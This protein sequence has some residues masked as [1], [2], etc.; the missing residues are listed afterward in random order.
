MALPLEFKTAKT[1]Q[2]KTRGLR[3][4]R[5]LGFELEAFGGWLSWSGYFCPAVCAVSGGM[6]NVMLVN[7]ISS[8]V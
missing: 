5:T 4:V 2:F 3:Q 8:H 1:F 7:I 6:W